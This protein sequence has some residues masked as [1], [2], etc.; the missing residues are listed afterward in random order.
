[1]A[2]TPEQSAASV[3]SW[4][5][6]WAGFHMEVNP[7]DDWESLD[8][9]PAFWGNWRSQ[10][11]RHGLHDAEVA[12]DA[13]QRISLLELRKKGDHL[14]HLLEAATEV[15]RER[16]ESF[17][18]AHGV[19]RSRE[20]AQEE[21]R[22][23]LD[24]NGVSGIAIRYVHAEL[25]GRFKTAAGR[26]L[27]F[28]ASIT[29]YC[30]CALGRW[31][32]VAE[33]VE[34]EPGRKGGRKE[35]KAAVHAT[36]RA[37]KVKLPDL[38]DYPDLMRSMQPWNAEAPDTRFRFRPDDWDAYTGQPMAPA[39]SLEELRA[40]VD[41]DILEQRKQ[42]REGIRDREERR[43]TDPAYGKP[44]PLYSAPTE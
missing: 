44:R 9:A 36:F 43:F 13:S 7:R 12:I 31:M 10:F 40:R 27:P 14:R 22:G 41:A 42:L 4:F 19:A 32:K 37:D 23:C 34:D 24:C 30:P 33:A 18:S 11:V 26:P 21:A 8:A 28:G 25:E 35:S 29:F 15:Y 39:V 38:V 16:R 3:E 5:D 2:K 6:G 20:A 17:Q 1:M